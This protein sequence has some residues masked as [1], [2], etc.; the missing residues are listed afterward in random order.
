MRTSHGGPWYQG[1][2]RL[3]GAKT[4]VVQ[5]PLEPEGGGEQ[6]RPVAGA[7]PAVV[8]EPDA[9]VVRVRGAAGEVL[10]VAL[11]VERLVDE[12]QA[13]LEGLAAQMGD[14]IGLT[15][16]GGGRAQRL[17]GADSGRG[18]RRRRASRAA[19]CHRG[20]CRALAP[21]RRRL[22][23]ARARLAGGGGRTPPRSSPRGS[24]ASPS[25]RGCGRRRSV[26]FQMGCSSRLP[27]RFVST[28]SG[29]P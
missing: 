13:D 4:D 26:G 8:V 21:G 19:R 22:A 29:I 9:A 1:C 27:S 16:R 3:A 17:E 23:A 18:D 10:E 15:A 6:R 5:Q 14:E 20:R 24:R 12:A 25:A 7:R 11:G 28:T 2:G